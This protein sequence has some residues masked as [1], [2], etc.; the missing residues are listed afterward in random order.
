M[1]TRA[2]VVW[3]LRAAEPVSRGP[4]QLPLANAEMLGRDLCSLR[5]SFFTSEWG[6]I[7]TPTL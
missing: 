3:W 5:I 4:S 6:I 2:C 1:W 7:I